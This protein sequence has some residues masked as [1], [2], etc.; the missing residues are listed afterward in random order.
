MQD[1]HKTWIE[2]DRRALCSNISEIR[3]LL[4]KEVE[5]CAVVKSNAYGHGLIEVAK[6]AAD[7][8]VKSFAVDNIDEALKLRKALPSVHI[9]ILG[10]TL[11]SR[12]TEAVENNIE[13]TIYNTESLG[14]LDKEAE[15]LKT[16]VKIHIKIE[17]GTNR[18]GIL[19]DDLEDFIKKIKQH[20]N[21][22]VVGI[23]T[24]FANIEDTSDHGYAMGQLEVF[25]KALQTALQHKLQPKYIHTA[26][27]AAAILF[28]ETHGN[29]VRV[30]ISTYGFW[31]S[32]QVEAAARR[33]N[34]RI[35]L[36]PVLTWKT[37]IAQIKDMP[38]GVPIGYGLTETLKRDGRIAI[39]PVG[40]WDGYDRRLSSVGE[41]LIHGQRCKVLGR[42]CM[43]M[44]MVDI[45]HLPQI[46][47]EEE[48][49]LL[50]R[51]SNNTVSA[52]DIA[53]KIGTIHYEVVTK[54]N[55]DLPRIVV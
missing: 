28:P 38:K 17:T 24:H 18:Q 6:I 49:I 23:S 30:G 10:Y 39:L 2:I 51:Q 54:M 16:K 12:L 48:V 8:G 31:P 3:S 11:Y 5:F 41:V 55:P 42:I 21:I 27:S 47:P 50:G 13:L 22:E 20:S 33:T 44:M 45:S 15:K 32:P 1:K 29:M 40:Y 9:L 37:R 34:R 36:K 43:N 26:C 46:Q 19:L 25:N 52:I 53:E 14:R 35:E 4:D 7:E